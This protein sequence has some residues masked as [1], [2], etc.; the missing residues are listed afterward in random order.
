MIPRAASLVPLA[1]PCRALLL[2]GLAGVGVRAQQE[3]LD[4][5]AK[6]LSQPGPEAQDVRFSAAQELLGRTD[7][8]AHQILHARIVL[9]EDPDGVRRMILE[10]LEARLRNSRDEVFGAETAG[11]DLA[12]RSKIHESYVGPLAHVMALGDAAKPAAAAPSALAR[13]CYLRLDAQARFDGVQR[14]LVDSATVPLGLVAARES[15]LPRAGR[16][17]AELLEHPEHAQP[18]RAALAA[19]TFHPGGFADAAAFEAWYEANQGLT[20]TDLAERAARRGELEIET[21]RRE[22]AQRLIQTRARLAVALCDAPEVAWDQ[23]ATLCGAQAGVDQVRACLAE[24]A[25]RLAE[26]LHEGNGT[27]ERRALHQSLVQRLDQPGAGDGLRPLILEVAA[28]LLRPTDPA[29]Q[30]LR[31]AM[32]T[33]LRGAIANGNGE[34]RLAAMRGIRRLYTVDNWRAVVEALDAELA[35]VQRDQGGKPSAPSQ[36]FLEAALGTLQTASPRWSTPA[37]EITSLRGALDAIMRLDDASAVQRQAIALARLP[38][39]SGTRLETMFEFL[40]QTAR[41]AQRRPEL[42]RLAFAYAQDF[43]GG[44]EGDRSQAYVEL[45]RDLLSAEETELRR[46]AAERLKR[47]TETDERARGWSSTILDAAR[48][49]LTVETDPSVYK[50]LVKVLTLCALP[51]AGSDAALESVMTALQNAIADVYREPI[52]GEVQF[53]ADP[54][55]GELNVLA[56]SSMASIENWTA[57]VSVL[58]ERDQRSRALDVLERQP[59]VDASEPLAQTAWALPLD[60]A[61]LRRPSEPLGVEEAQAVREAMRLLRTKSD[62]WESASTRLLEVEVANALGE[63][64]AALSVGDGLLG[65]GAANFDRLPEDDDAGDRVAVA[66]GQARARAED[67]AGAV[68][69]LAGTTPGGAYAPVAAGLLEE[70]VL[71]RRRADPAVCLRAAKAM[72]ALLN[73]QSPQFRG[74]FLLWAEVHQEHASAEHQ[75]VRAALETWRALFTAADCP[76]PLRERYE[77][78]LAKLAAAPA[79]G[80]GG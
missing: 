7:P 32:G 75:T 80:S 77:T 56:A 17:L 24:I 22:S 79:A 49:R 59:P 78:L 38:D 23:L 44:E 58:V 20:Y 16:L 57:A 8:R 48:G 64:E 40:T 60:V 50:E 36:R 51:P 9:D 71:D 2:V 29:E 21:V 34:V 13:S 5:L 45:A 46:L 39:A 65:G 52:R 35:A 25:P 68:E 18:A 63:Y 41:A 26:R 69:L 28:Y 27:R 66:L 6:E 33:R 14:L 55:F 54:L 67:P 37:E 31:Q 62:G 1:T 74:R 10:R 70:I 15:R 19:L 43:V 76:A 11:R 73:D 47:L 42:R 53:R 12:E 4:R 61:L 3:D 30:D 72:R